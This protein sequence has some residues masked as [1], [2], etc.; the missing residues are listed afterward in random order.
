MSQNLVMQLERARIMHAR[1]IPHAPTA[2]IN[3]VT[4][5]DVW[6]VTKETRTTQMVAKVRY[7]VSAFSNEAIYVCNIYVL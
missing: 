1:R 6:K 3:L 2:P 7:L 5:A 4:F